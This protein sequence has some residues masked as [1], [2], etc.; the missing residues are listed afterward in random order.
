MAEDA[1]LDAIRDSYTA[2]YPDMPADAITH[3][4]EFAKNWLLEKGVI[5]VGQTT[6]GFSIRFADASEILFVNNTQ[7]ADEPSSPMAI[8]GLASRRQNVMPDTSRSVNIT[9][10]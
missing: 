5:G 2:K 9:G 7:P 1:L 8:T 10:R 6:E 3:F 4:C